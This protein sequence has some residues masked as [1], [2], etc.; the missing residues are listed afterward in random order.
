MKLTLS[1]LLIFVVNFA[2]SQETG[3]IKPIDAF[4]K[5]G[6][7]ITYF[8]TPPK[9]L[10]LP[11]SLQ[12]VILFLGKNSQ[13]KKEKLSKETNG[14][15]FNFKAP[16]SISVIIIGI[17]DDKNRI[18]DNNNNH[19]YISYFYDKNNHK[20]AVADI[21][22]ATMLAGFTNYFLEVKESNEDILKLY[23]NT[24][25]KNPSLVY[26]NNYNSYL[27]T[28]Y[29]AKKQAA[30]PKIIAYGKKIESEYQSEPKLD[31]IKYLYQNAGLKEEEKRI[32][33]I[34]LK[35][36]PSGQ[37]ARETFMN[38]YFSSDKNTEEDILA[39]MKNYIE[40]FNDSSA[41]AKQNFYSD[42]LFLALQSKNWDNILKYEELSPNKLSVAMKYNSYAWNL[43]G[44]NIEDSAK[45]PEFA[46]IISRRSIDVIESMIKQNNNADLW[47]NWD[48]YTD[49]Y[50]LILYKQKQFDS[51]FYYQD[52]ILKRS[53]SMG[54]DGKERYALFASSAKGP[55]F[56]KEFIE[57][58]LSNG[59]TSS[60]L[61][62]S[63]KTIYQ[64]LNLPDEE[65]V[66]IKAKGDALLKEKME[67]QIKAK[68][69]SVIAKDF[70]LTNLKGQKV[71]LSSF[72]NKIVIIDFW[73]TWCGPCRSS[74]PGTQ[75]LINKYKN[76][77]DI[78]FLFIDTWER[79]DLKQMRNE[80]Q[81]FITK[82][83][84][85]FEVLL[86]DKD[87]VVGDYKVDG[88]PT[89]FIIDKSGK[90]AFMGHPSNDIGV[91]IEKL[92]NAN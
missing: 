17:K 51:A 44:A 43:C 62:E 65:F 23:E 61:L 76:Q 82:N 45:E 80:A 22:L 75:Q 27:N 79:K 81:D 91:E 12:A 59:V 88:I 11:D 37:I 14:Y 92:K 52:A 72:K 74:F 64:E 33:E 47:N 54:V 29:R 67:K 16:D 41:F 68:L 19:G 63:L 18:V 15:S 31:E 13:T 85:T 55:A 24:Y 26:K 50:A 30:I 9:D 25:K 39:S 78:A 10:S 2:S 53:N 42:I 4:P 66:K 77:P 3:K 38:N 56:A 58:E 36:F 6:T 5:T 83:N 49:T 60:R 48:G 73:A 86:D 34:I 1:A 40:K 28:L 71:S 89:T 20:A 90:I 7:E 84:Y 46:K 21:E 57:K 70:I 32:T 8:Y 87:K 35:K 69:G